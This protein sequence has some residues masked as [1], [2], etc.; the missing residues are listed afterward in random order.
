METIR[1]CICS[2]SCNTEIQNFQF[3][4][5][6][7]LITQK[8]LNVENLY[9]WARPPV[10]VPTY[11]T[12]F[13]CGST[14][15]LACC[16]FIAL[17]RYLLKRVSMQLDGILR[18]PEYAYSWYMISEVPLTGVNVARL[19]FRPPALPRCTY[20]LSIC[21]LTRQNVDIIVR[22]YRYILMKLSL[23]RG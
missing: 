14:F 23:T 7:A 10:C 12:C 3:R 16:A 6:I 15:A 19:C 20:I 2:K 17:T 13:D 18:P 22:K 11:L 21:V 4:K 1:I 9:G 8:Y 5:R